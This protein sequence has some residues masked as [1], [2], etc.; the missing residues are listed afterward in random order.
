MSGRLAIVKYLVCCCALALFKIALKRNNIP[1]KFEPEQS[2]G[3]DI[4]YLLPSVAFFIAAFSSAAF[5]K[6]VVIIASSKVFRACSA[7]VKASRS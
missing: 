7:S 4:T 2:T 5:S 1:K 3:H 6:A